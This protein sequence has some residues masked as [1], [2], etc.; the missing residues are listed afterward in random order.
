MKIRIILGTVAAFFL[1]SP[2]YAQVQ[3]IPIQAMSSVPI[4]VETATT[5]QLVAPVTGAK[6]FV[7]NWNVISNGTGTVKLEYGTGSACTGTNALTGSYPLT[8]QAGL[9]PGGIGSVLIVPAG[10][11]L[12]I[13]TT[14]SA[15]ADGSLAYAQF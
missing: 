3:G 14:S 11:G 7:T 9:A 6:I 12:C 8:A 2:G 10:N 5:T 1:S 13:V 4:A 15:T